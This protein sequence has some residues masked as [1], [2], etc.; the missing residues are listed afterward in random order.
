MRRERRVERF[1]QVRQRH[2]QGHP[3][4]QIARDLGIPTGSIGPTRARCFRKLEKILVEMGVERA[5]VE[6]SAPDGG[7]LRIAG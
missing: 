4:R 6:R 1:E 2:R 7:V 5:D 3:A